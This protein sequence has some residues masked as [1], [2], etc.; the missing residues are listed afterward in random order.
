MATGKIAIALVAAPIVSLSVHLDTDIQRLLKI[1]PLEL[2]PPP[3]R[4]KTIPTVTS[5]DPGPLVTIA[6]ILPAIARGVGLVTRLRN[7]VHRQPTTDFTIPSLVVLP[8]LMAKAIASARKENFSPLPVPTLL[9]PRGLR[10]Q[11]FKPR[12]SGWATPSAQ[13]LEPLA[14]Q[15][16]LRRFPL[17]HRVHRL[18]LK[19]NFV[20]FTQFLT[21]IYRGLYQVCLMNYIT[22]DSFILRIAR[23]TQSLYTYRNFT[24]IHNRPCWLGIW[25]HSLCGTE[26]EGNS[27]FCRE[28]EFLPLPSHTGPSIR[29]FSPA[30]WS[31]FLFYSFYFFSR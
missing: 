26:E 25:T 24:F 21:P 7:H 31:I 11:P 9:D 6:A 15:V 4:V 2:R 1:V 17:P 19:I 12:I 30:S 10:V 22:F 13:A 18:S 27:R 16:P 29:P 23:P 8:L 20:I 28:Y 5:R 14:S 3:T